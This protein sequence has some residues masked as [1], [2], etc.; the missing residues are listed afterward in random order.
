M[1][2]HETHETPDGTDTRTPEQ[3]EAD[4]EQ[5]REQ[6]AETIDAL[7]AKID[8]KARA[9]DQVAD[10]KDRATTDDG[11]PRPE[12]LAGVGLVVAVVVGVLVWRRRR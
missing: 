2:T 11:K 8:V 12:V 6:L 10:L 7:T 5:Q 9:K 3:I 1:T 4:I